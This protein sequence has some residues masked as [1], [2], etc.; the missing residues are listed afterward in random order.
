MNPAHGKN[1]VYSAAE[2]G[3][4]YSEN[5]NVWLLL[6]VLEYNEFGKAKKLR[7]LKSAENKDGLYDYLM[8]EDE[9]WTWKKK[10]IFVFSDPDKPCELF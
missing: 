10:Y 5:P 6:E 9:D 3:G 7:L 8:D 4:L 2:M 1:K